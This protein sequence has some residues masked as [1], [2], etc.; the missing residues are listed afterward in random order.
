MTDYLVGVK[1]TK[2]FGLRQKILEDFI[3][4]LI[5]Y[6]GNFATYLRLPSSDW[7][8]TSEWRIA[9]L[10]YLMEREREKEREKDESL[11][12]KSKFAASGCLQKG[13]CVRFGP[14]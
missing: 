7:Q 10:Q 13:H 9:E 4:H 6:I 5:N 12:A 8:L 11:K 1:F 2:V 3:S 14:K